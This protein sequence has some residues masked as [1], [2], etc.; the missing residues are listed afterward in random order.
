MQNKDKLI[1]AE[2]AFCTNQI[3]GTTT[4]LNMLLKSELASEFK[5]MPVVFNQSGNGIGFF[6]A[7][8]FY[9]KEFKKINPD[10]VV[11]RGCEKEGLAGQIGAKLA[12]VG[13][14]LVGCHGLHSKIIKTSRIKHWISLHIIEPLVFKYCDYFYTVSES[15]FSQYKLFKKNEKKYLGVL[16]NASPDYPVLNKNIYRSQLHKELNL[17]NSTTL[18]IY[19]GRFTFDKGTDVLINAL[20]AFFKQHTNSNFAFIFVGDGKE[21]EERIKTVFKDEIKNKKVYLFKSTS[22][23]M[24]YLLGS[25]LYIHPSYHDNHSLSLLEACAAGCFVIATKVG[26]VEETVSPTNSLLVDIGDYMAISNSIELFLERQSNFDCLSWTKTKK[27]IFSKDNIY[28]QRKTLYK[29]AIQKFKS[30]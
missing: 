26:G 6:K 25:D 22:E 1:V 30:K 14:I 18:G 2:Q 12:G 23:I 15:V 20:K 17:P 19:H 11:I 28:N 5:L 13:P 4:E 10:I 24:R 7:I 21:Y 29:K 8:S 16:Y 3:G 9:K 27:P